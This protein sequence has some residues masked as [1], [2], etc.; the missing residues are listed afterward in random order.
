M[1]FLCGMECEHNYLD[2]KYLKH[3]IT[4]LKVS[5]VSTVIYVYKY[6]FF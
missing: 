2:V 5:N 3:V 6:I 4:K 1:S